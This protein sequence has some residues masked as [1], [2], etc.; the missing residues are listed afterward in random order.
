MVMRSGDLVGE[1]YRL[2]RPIGS[3]GMATVF[4]ALDV[5]LER[6]VAAKFLTARHRNPAT[7]ERRFLREARIA[8]AVRH[9]NVVEVYDFGVAGETPYM[10]MELLE[11][12]SLAD[13]ARETPLL[14]LGELFDV[15]DGVLAGLGAVHDAGIVH[16]DVKPENIF[17]VRAPAGATLAKIFDFGVSKI[18]TDDG[19]IS[20]STSVEGYLVGTPHYMSSEQARGLRDLDPTTD[21]YSVGVVLYEHLAGR[22]P[23]DAEHVGDLVIAIATATPP[24]LDTLRPELGEALARFVERAMA[25]L[26]ADRFPSAAAMREALAAIRAGAPELEALSTRVVERGGPEPAPTMDPPEVPLPWSGREEPDEPLE[27]DFGLPDAPA[28]VPAPPRPRAILPYA[29][30]AAAAV[31]ALTF[32]GWLTLRGDDAPQTPPSGAPTTEALLTP[33]TPPPMVTVRVRG[34]PAGA[35]VFLDGAPATGDELTLAR[36]ESQHSLRVEAEGAEVFSTAFV[37]D[38][39]RTV[40][41]EL[42]PRAA[43][44]PVAAPVAPGEPG[45]TRGRRGRATEGPRTSGGG[46]FRDPDF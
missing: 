34:V 29:L 45:S 24:R 40:S 46:I 22:L 20:T 13:R 17:L 37:A 31:A 27:L 32:V 36:D 43:P 7:V 25:K 44:D 8:A 30:A 19:P 2:G 11:G 9:P 5:T 26:P 23:F 42:T 10:V 1:R 18:Q 39:D 4:E 28:E 6:R 15:I 21:V 3:G 41:V 35:A 38:V 16:R 12:A 33:A 14:T